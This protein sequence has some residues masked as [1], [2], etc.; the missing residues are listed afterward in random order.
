MR[1]YR[2]L[3]KQL[4]EDAPEKLTRL[5]AEFLI[6]QVRRLLERDEIYVLEQV[7]KHV[8][9]M[10]GLPIEA[11]ARAAERALDRG[12]V[13]DFCF[14]YAH[15]P[16]SGRTAPER[17]DRA[18]ARLAR[19]GN[20]GGIEQIIAATGVRPTLD[21][22]TV[23]R[24]YD[25]LVAAGRLG[26]VDYM[27]QLSGV[28]VRFDPEAA[29]TGIRTLL[30][31]GRHG[32]LRK[33]A[34]LADVE[35]RLDARE[36]HR[37]VA[38]AVTDGTLHDLAKALACLRPSP[39][40]EG[41]AEV[42]RRLV[43]EDRVAELPALFTVFADA[44]WQSLDAPLW[45]RLLSSGSAPALRFAF[46]R[47]D[48]ADLLAHH[49]QQAYALGVSAGDRALVE[50]AC[51]RGGVR[52]RAEDV[53][54]LL[55]DA[56]EDGDAHWLDFV[57]ARLPSLPAVDPDRAQLYLALQAAVRPQR[58][59]R[60]AE[61]LGVPWAPEVGRWLLALTEGRHEEAAPAAGHATGHPIATAVTTPPVRDVPA[62]LAA[63]TAPPAPDT[64]ADLA[65]NGARAS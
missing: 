34:R 58:V 47:Y 63:V 14:L 37:A 11:V 7:N 35:V 59:E 1:A 46:E 53:G 49:A 36:I 4:A 41:F 60:D 25:V 44:D 9:V 27:R 43:S 48:N 20:A 18:C 61:T 2:N 54:V 45:Q 62:D 50:L 52:L 24:S 56:L 23:L 30:A 13:D 33:L 29:A 19:R 31:S 64:P 6:E 8:P 3:F 28:R 39:R 57:T 15:L 26:A 21:E 10:A 22:E 65:A 17:I 42:F 5:P 40:I 51:E 32:P 16:A 38:E 55:D 12:V